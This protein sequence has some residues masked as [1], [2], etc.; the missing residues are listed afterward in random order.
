MANIALFSTVL[1][2]PKLR[3]IDTLISVPVLAL[4]QACSIFLGMINIDDLLLTNTNLD[5][6]GYVISGNFS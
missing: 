1:Q 2:N 6:G 4:I 5:H 3:M